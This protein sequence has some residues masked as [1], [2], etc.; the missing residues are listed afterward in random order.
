MSAPHLPEG[1][2]VP[3]APVRV[4]PLTVDLGT[5]A[6]QRVVLL[7]LEVWPQ[8]A[9]LRFARIDVGATR[10]LPRRVPPVDA[11]QVHLD[12][13]PLEV[14]DAV[15]RGDRSFSNG[16]V[17]LRPVPPEGS[18]LE[19]RVTVIPGHEPLTATVAL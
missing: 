4:V 14:L 11:W 8:W 17:R 5:V 2:A 13:R 7:S 12:G 19:V 16:E 18:S 1:L 3:D 6:G 9:D 15:G 10:P